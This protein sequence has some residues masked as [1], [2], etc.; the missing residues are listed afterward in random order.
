MYAK[1]AKFVDLIIYLFEDVW[2]PSLNERHKKV[3]ELDLDCI[4]GMKG[5]IALPL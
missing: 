2:K 3:D 5:S 4:T 1:L